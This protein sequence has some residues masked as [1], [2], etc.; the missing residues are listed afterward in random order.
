MAHHR[1]VGQPCGRTIQP[2]AMPAPDTRVLYDGPW[3]GPAMFH[4][5]TEGCD[6]RAI[7]AEHGFE[8]LYVTLEEDQGDDSPLSEKY[9]AG[10][11][12]E[13]VASC[14]LPKPRPGWTLSGMTDTEDGLTALFLRPVSAQQEDP[15]HDGA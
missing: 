2:A 7:A 8:T 13:V 12:A 10:E 1:Q 3:F 11:G 9:A 15:T 14:W 6:A 5:A 4:Y